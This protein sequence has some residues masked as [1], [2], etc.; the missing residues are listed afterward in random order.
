ML[1]IFDCVARVDET[2]IPDFRPRTVPSDLFSLDA[3]S[4]ATIAGSSTRSGNVLGKVLAESV[5]RKVLFGI[6]MEI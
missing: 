3:P 2:A 5:R 4:V 6:T 1:D